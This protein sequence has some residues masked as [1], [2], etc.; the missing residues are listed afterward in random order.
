MDLCCGFRPLLFTYVLINGIFITL[1]TKEGE[2]IF[3]LSSVRSFFFFLA[4]RRSKWKR[5]D[6]RHAG[7]RLV[8]GNCGERN[9][10][11]IVVAVKV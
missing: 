3:H 2:L 4:L 9:A 6:R 7:I 8:R 5:S 1:Q 10:R 11:W